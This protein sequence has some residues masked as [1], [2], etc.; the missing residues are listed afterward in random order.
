MLITTPVVEKFEATSRSAHGLAP[1]SNNRF[2]RPRTTGYVHT[3]Y[4]S[5]SDAAC[6]G[7]PGPI[8]AESDGPESQIDP[9]LGDLGGLRHA[10]LPEGL[11]CALHDKEAAV[12]ELDRDRRAITFAFV[13]KGKFSFSTKAERANRGIFPEH[14][15]VVA[16]PAHALGVTIRPR[17]GPV[18]ILSKS[19]R[20]NVI[21]LNDAPGNCFHARMIA[22]LL[23]SFETT[24]LASPNQPLLYFFA[25]MNLLLASINHKLN[26]QLIRSMLHCI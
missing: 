19:Q 23:F 7:V 17:R 25:V 16:V 24:N 12:L 2:P 13:A 22:R 3:L 21:E 1:F 15:F 18:G 26:T 8:S 11:S 6:R 9:G 14:L 5:M 10:M 20:V 4:S